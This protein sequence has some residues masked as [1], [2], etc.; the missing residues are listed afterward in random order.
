MMNKS[1]WAAGALWQRSPF[2]P[3]RMII[4]AKTLLLRRGA[5]GWQ[6]NPDL[7]PVIYRRRLLRA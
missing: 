7:K 1:V 6:L 5:A 4:Y 2:G 3:G